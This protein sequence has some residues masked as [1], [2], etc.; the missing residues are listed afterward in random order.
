MEGS[1]LHLH[2]LCIYIHVYKYINLFIYPVT[3]CRMPLPHRLRMPS[4]Q[5]CRP[6]RLPS[7]AGCRCAAGCR[8]TPDAGAP[9][10]AVFL[11]RA[12]GCRMTS[13]PLL[14]AGAG[15]RRTSV[16]FRRAAG[17]RSAAVGRRSGFGWP[18]PLRVA[19]PPSHLVQVIL[20][21]L[22]STHRH[23][24]NSFCSTLYTVRA[25]FVRSMWD[26]PQFVPFSSQ[27]YT[28]IS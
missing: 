15:C 1:N 2:S 11:L 25:L 9:P 8:R 19:R 20:N 4:D 22:C 5:P 28:L 16:P 12:A 13:V 18:K 10:V 23:K 24:G 7:V 17:C 3:G 27:L 21:S 26:I 6:R 14:D